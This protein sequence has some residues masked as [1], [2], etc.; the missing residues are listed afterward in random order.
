MA[1]PSLLHE[2]L[3]RSEEAKTS[4]DRSFGLTFAA[5][6]AILGLWPLWHGQA[7]RWWLLG[8]VLALIVVSLA[9]PALLAPFN[10]VWQRIG[11]LL[12][13]IVNPL[14]LGIV[15]YGVVTPLGLFLR[16]RGKDPLRL[17]FDPSAASYWIERDPP[18]PAP[19]SM[20]RQF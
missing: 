20:N 17:S 18:G 5:V 4:S 16:A 12:H 2:D 14:V 9:A 13:R 1:Q 3:H 8:L 7:P 6:G 10:R 15:F 11:L 19:K